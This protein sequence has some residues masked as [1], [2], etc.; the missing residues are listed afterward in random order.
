[1]C[2]SFRSGTSI[3][4][5][6]LS[7]HSEIIYT[8]ELW[9][10][11]NP[12]IIN[13]KIDKLDKRYPKLIGR[14]FIPV[15]VLQDNYKNFLDEW[16]N[17]P[18]K[19]GTDLVNR[20]LKYSPRINSKI[21]GDKLPEYVFDLELLNK[22]LKRPKVLMCIRDGRDVI[23]SQIFRYNYFMKLHGKIGNHFWC[24][25]TVEECIHDWRNWL[26]YMIAWDS[27]KDKIDHYEIYYN[28][29]IQ[30]PEKVAKEV[31]EFLNVNSEEM[32]KIFQKNI[33]A[34][35]KNIW[36]KYHPNMNEKLP[37]SWKQMLEKYGFEI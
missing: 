9:T 27:I 17:N 34:K 23:Q 28:R 20:L 5:I 12:I 4:S 29:L 14:P 31:A 21:Y 10:Y 35:R 3:C 15:S 18:I 2:G 6:L 36:K 33:H 16:K 25:S 30:E 22:L 1:M 13:K 32:I 7:K 37:E 8:D 11:R 19:S 24:H 26:R